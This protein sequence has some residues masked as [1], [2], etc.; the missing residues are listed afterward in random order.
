M[1]QILFGD[2][3]HT[4]E[5]GPYKRLLKTRKWLYISSFASL[6]ISNGLYDE[7][8]AARV[9][10]PI[11][12]PASALETS[13]RIGLLYLI[14]QY[15]LLLIQLW[16]SYDIVL[17]ERFVFRRADELTKARERFRS[18]R[19]LDSEALVVPILTSQACQH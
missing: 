4:A 11:K 10:S 9:L 19:K 1:L 13:L 17:E 6:L 14:V 3:E 7:T 5:E 16:T 18:A 15:I 2:D 12:L 8:S